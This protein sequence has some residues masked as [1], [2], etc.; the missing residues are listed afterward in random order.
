MFGFL[1]YTRKRLLN[2]IAAETASA[3]QSAARTSQ[4]THPPTAIRTSQRAAQLPSRHLHLRFSARAN[5]HDAHGHA[6]ESTAMVMAQARPQRTSGRSTSIIPRRPT[7]SV[8]RP[9]GLTY[10]SIMKLA[11]RSAPLGASNEPISGT[12]CEARTLPPSFT[13][14]S[15]HKSGRSAARLDASRRSP[16]CYASSRDRIGTLQVE[17]PRSQRSVTRAPNGRG[18]IGGVVIGEEAH[19]HTHTIATTS[20]LHRGLLPVPCTAGC[21]RH[22][23]RCSRRCTYRFG[24]QQQRARK[25]SQ[26]DSDRASSSWPD[27]PSPARF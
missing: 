11:R 22:S 1:C 12:S 13:S 14:T 6:V 18:L 7:T 19:H 8:A 2:R 25:R 3:G 9:V 16:T 27:L 4:C 21:R 17:F 26:L 24:P 5:G 10:L 23:R 20:T 15:T